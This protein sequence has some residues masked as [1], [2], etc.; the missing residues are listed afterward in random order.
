[1]Y[2]KKIIS[3]TN[4][5]DFQQCTGIITLCMSSY[6]KRSIGVEIVQKVIEN[7]A[8]NSVKNPDT[9]EATELLA[10]DGICPYMIKDVF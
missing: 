5:S 6:T 8:L 7:A 10:K 1:M 9:S 2:Y 4:W 3:R